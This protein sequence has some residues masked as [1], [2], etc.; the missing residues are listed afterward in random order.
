MRILIIEKEIRLVDSLKVVLKQQGW[1][2]DV[3]Y[4]GATGLE[5]AESE[6]YDLLVLDEQ[7]PNLDGWCLVKHIRND[8][9]DIPILMLTKTTD[10]EERIKGLNSGVDYCI[11]KPFDPRELL[12]C[13][14]ALLRRQNN[15]SD[16]LIFG[17]TALELESA[18][19]VCGTNTIRLSAKEFEIMRLLFKQ[20]NRNL[21]KETILAHVWGYDSNAV[22]NHVEVYIGFLRKKLAHIGSNVKIVAVRRLGY[23]LESEKGIE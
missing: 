5:Y 23:H 14:R 16:T 18:T 19:L 1:E 10:L 17:N 4:D 22:E 21:S 13:I 8:H 15:Q 7:L 20:P 3:V 9:F 6:F 2:I 11:A 12:A